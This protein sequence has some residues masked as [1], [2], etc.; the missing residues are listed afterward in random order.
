M[1]VQVYQGRNWSLAEDHIHFTIGRQ[2]TYLKLVQGAHEAFHCL[3][4]KH[5]EQSPTQQLL[6]LREYLLVLK[7]GLFPCLD[8]F[9]PRASC[10]RELWRASLKGLHPRFFSPQKEGAEP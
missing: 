5:S 2:S 8:V 4:A 10:A 1:W 7:V 3:L 6:F 9:C